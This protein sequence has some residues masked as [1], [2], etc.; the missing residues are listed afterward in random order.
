[1]PQ[2]VIPFKPN[3][4][5]FVMAILIIMA[6]LRLLFFV[7]DA[8]LYRSWWWKRIIALMEI[9][10]WRDV[11][12]HPLAGK[13]GSVLARRCRNCADKTTDGGTM[14]VCEV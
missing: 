7:Q 5:S 3:S 13:C 4:R 1:M 9:I 2:T 11:V 10:R 8:L 6:A 12:N 14:E